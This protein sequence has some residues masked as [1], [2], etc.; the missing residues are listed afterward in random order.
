MEYLLINRSSLH[1]LCSSIG[2]IN[3]NGHYEMNPHCLATLISIEQQLINE[4]SITRNIRIGLGLS[5]IIERDL[6]GILGVTDLFNNPPIIRITVRLLVNLTLPSEVILPVSLPYYPSRASP[7][8]PPNESLTCRVVQLQKMLLDAKKAFIKSNKVTSSLIATMK[9]VPLTNSSDTFNVNRSSSSTTTT[10]T[11]T[12]SSNHYINLLN[13]H[14]IFTDHPSSGFNEST[15]DKIE[16]YEPEIA[17]TINVGMG[18]GGKT[19][20]DWQDSQRRIIWNLLVQGLDNTLLFL[21]STPYRRNWICQIVQ[22]ITLLY[23]NQPVSKLIQCISTKD[24]TS[25]CSEDD[26]DS[27][28]TLSAQRSSS[29]SILSDSSSSKEC[30]AQSSESKDDSGY[31]QQTEIERNCPES[32]CFENNKNITQNDYQQSTTNSDLTEK[33]DTSVPTHSTSNWHKNVTSRECDDLPMEN[34]ESTESN[35]KNEREKNRPNQINDE[36]KEYAKTETNLQESVRMEEDDCANDNQTSGFSGSSEED[37]RRMHKVKKPHQRSTT[38]PTD[39]DDSDDSDYGAIK[40]M[41]CHHHPPNVTRKTKIC[42]PIPRSPN[43]CPSICMETA[44]AAAL[45]AIS[46]SA[47]SLESSQAKGSPS[48]S[49]NDQSS[50]LKSTSSKDSIKSDK[51]INSTRIVNDSQKSTIN[52]ETQVKPIAPWDKK[53]TCGSKSSSIGNESIAPSDNDICSLLKEF[54]LK[55]VHN[56]FS[57]LI[58]DLSKELIL[59][60]SCSSNSHPLSPSTSSLD[61]SHL[62]WLISYFLKI[63]SSIDLN[64]NHLSPILQ[65]DMFGFLVYNGLM[66]NEEIESLSTRSV[67]ITPITTTESPPRSRS[68]SLPVTVMTTESKSSK[69]PFASSSS[70]PSSNNQQ[71]EAKVNMI[72]DD[73]IKK[74]TR[75]LQLLITALK[76]M[77]ITVSGYIGKSSS[78]EAEKQ[79]LNNLRTSLAN[80]TALRQFFLLVTRCYSPVIHP[81][82]FLVDSIVTHHHLMLLLDEPFKRGNCN[83]VDHL[84]QFATIKVMEQYGRVLEAFQSNNELINNCV[85]TIMHHVAGDLRNPECLFQPIIL[86]TFSLIMESDIELTDSWEDLMEYVMNRFV[87]AATRS[88]A[89]RLNKLTDTTPIAS[90]SKID[91]S[92][93]PILLASSLSSST[94]LIGSIIS[95]S[96][97]LMGE[98]EG[99]DS[100]RQPCDLGSIA[101]STHQTR[102]ATICSSS[103]SYGSDGSSSIDL[104]NLDT[105][106]DQLYWLYLQYEQTNDPISCILEVIMEEQGI[107]MDRAELISQLMVKGIISSE[108]YNRFMEYDYGLSSIKKLEEETDGGRDDEYEDRMS[109]DNI[110]DIGQDN[111]HHDSSYQQQQMDTSRVTSLNG[112]KCDNVLDESRAS[113]SVD[114]ISTIN[115]DSNEDR[116]MMEET[117]QEVA[118]I[119]CLIDKLIKMGFSDQLTWIGSILLDIINVKMCQVKSVKQDSQILEPIAYFSN[120]LGQP[121]P[122]VPFN[123]KQELAL[124]SKPMVELLQRI[125]FQLPNDVSKL[126]PRIPVIF[127]PDIMFKIAC[128]ISSPKH[129]NLLF[130]PEEILET[131]KS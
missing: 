120:L 46:V 40:V 70:S 3:E 1:A 103:K 96:S 105:N 25:D 83:L 9:L 95:P 5:H 77:I 28:H 59:S 80:M 125:G 131:E 45:S 79:S 53:K 121:V 37:D 66:L 42:S 100:E 23:K 113:S 41:R 54:T 81:K 4:S 16:P 68:S 6:L 71:S 90:T 64:Y 49:T 118:E 51:G 119:D 92:I 114:N 10:T 58:L 126:Y 94:G 124:N 84:Q 2:W 72:H 102:G 35:G 86:K 75:K 67:G 17:A 7:C 22:L 107:T 76:E 19:K 50:T 12:S 98:D 11:T 20:E 82:S 99:V 57:C 65:I 117:A 21:M 88:N 29:T 32:I 104:T 123:E 115:H 129:G 97:H 61:L 109:H 106:H 43:C 38:K 85:F 56:F 31:Y 91:P 63:S 87:K 73:L 18:G 127:T 69:C 47:S 89:N 14:S 34:G 116:V 122:I 55:F 26:A 110:N 15:E 24:S 130:K 60:S 8:K 93:N 111:H 62:L 108:E 78:D 39:L 33:M 36:E 48:K 30:G 52:S 74:L 112:F 101:T 13:S 128:K 44:I 27:D